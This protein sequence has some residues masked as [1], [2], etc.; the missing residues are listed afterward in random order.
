MK[1]ILIF[2]ILIPIF[3]NIEF[4]DFHIYSTLDSL[5]KKLKTNIPEYI[6]DIRDKI[7]DFKDM[8]FET[9]Q[10]ILNELNDTMKAVI[11]EIKENK[12]N[13]N[14]S[15]KEFIEEGT[16]IA[17]LLTGRDCGILD[18][19]P[20]YECS[21]I[22]KYILK[23]IL[24]TIRDEFQCSKIIELITTNLI[25]KSLTNN[26]KS[27][28]FFIE[29]LSSN[30][31]AFIEGSAQILFDVINCMQEKLDIYWPKIE[32]YIDMKE[33]SSEVKKD[34]LFILI[35]SLTNLIELVRQEEKDG[36]LTKLNGLI[37][38]DMA[39]KLQKSIF[40]FAKVFN[41]FGTN[42]YNISS[43]FALNVIVNPGALGLS[44][45]SQVFVSNNDNKGI[46]LILHTNY[47]LRM[48]GAYSMQTIVFDSPLVSVRAKREVEKDISN[49]FV[50]ITLYD[51]DGNEIYVTDI[52]IEDFR[53]QILYE[54]K[55][56]NAMKT[57]LFYNEDDDKLESDG[58]KTEDNYF[59][60]GKSYIRCIPKHLSV[61]TIGVSEKRLYTLKRIMIIIFL[62]LIFMILTIIGFICFRKR[63]NKKINNIDIENISGK[64]KNYMGLDEEKSK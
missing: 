27:V 26:L 3:I 64:T 50:G 42:F 48:K 31:D 21:E 59:L 2:L 53:P 41:E 63:T 1:K 11:K 20:F 51:K 7:I 36:I 6:T 14:E 33:I 9:Q 37:Y 25:S 49:Y 18:Y 12:D 24:G 46:K 4:P 15:I 47:L 45:D 56:Y 16:K 22:K 32:D 38:T 43:S 35:H 60:D 17:G 61:F 23:Q 5:L 30:P 52:N 62:I 44:T 19:I 8:A 28:L 55:L 40:N 29:T 13:I 34:S 39:K 58:I 10:E 57:C 54:K